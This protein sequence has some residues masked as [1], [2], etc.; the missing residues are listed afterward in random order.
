[1]KENNMLDAIIRCAVICISGL[2]FLVGAC[3]YAP[4]HAGGGRK[5]LVSTVCVPVAE[6]L[7]SR[8][9][10]GPELTSA[11]ERRL[12]SAGVRVVGPGNGGA[13]LEV[14]ILAVEDSPGA[15]RLEAGRLAPVDSIWS[16]EA[17]AS[18][19]RG[20]G[21]VLAGPERFKVEGRSIYGDTPLAAEGLGWRTRAE[22]LDALADRIAEALVF[23]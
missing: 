12:G 3:G 4:L 2:L 18:L 13:R 22:L 6:N 9:G 5:T 21:A 11:L 7:T 23:R 20:D 1:M 16:I 17:E 14:A 19:V 10:I 15:L 8:V